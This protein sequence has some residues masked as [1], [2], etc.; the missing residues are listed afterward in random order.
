M[1]LLIKN[2][3][4][5]YSFLSRNNLKINDLILTNKKNAECQAKVQIR[6]KGGFKN[7]T[8]FYKVK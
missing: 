5:L 7:K 2:I 8:L 6:K 3:Q 4:E 1:K